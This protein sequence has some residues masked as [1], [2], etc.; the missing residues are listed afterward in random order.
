MKKV[1]LYVLYFVFFISAGFASAQGFKGLI[2][3]ESTC[4]DVK[5]I[6][7]VEKCSD[8]YSVYFFKDFI[9]GVYF[10]TDP[11]SE[12]DRWCYN[13]PTGTVTSFTFSFNKRIPMEDFEYELKFAERI[14]N[15][16]VTIVYDNREKGVGAYVHNGLITRAFFGPTPEQRKKYAYDCKS[17]CKQENHDE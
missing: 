16:I 4:E 2:P 12:E 11:P 6:L 17:A 13:V 10:K 7:K 14:E 15:D 1:N 5:R 9:V 8:P 3:L